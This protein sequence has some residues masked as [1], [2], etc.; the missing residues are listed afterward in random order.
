MGQSTNPVEPD[1]L[2]E[3]FGLVIA[4]LC[5]G[6]MTLWALDHAVA[7][8]LAIPGQ[9]IGG[10]FVFVFLAAIGVGVLLS[11]VRQIVVNDFL[12]KLPWLKVPT[13]QDYEEAL[14]KEPGL[15]AAYRD[16]RSSYFPYF[17]FFSHMFVA[18][19]IVF[20]AWWATATPSGRAIWWGIAAFLAI[21]GVLLRNAVNSMS[22]LR[23]RRSKL[24]SPAARIAS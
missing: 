4:Y 1:K 2:L 3:A 5:P 17:Q 22:R 21:E 10:G 24:L 9:A 23:A 16:I 7:G 13:E 8:G 12:F 18:A 6:F 11:G 19:P 14:R 20:V 15:E